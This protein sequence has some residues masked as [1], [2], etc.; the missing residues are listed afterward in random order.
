MGPKIATCCYCGTRAALKLKGDVQHE[1]ACGSCGAPLHEIKQMPLT[2][3]R[4]EKK[5][6]YETPVSFRKQMKSK[7]KYKKKKKGFLSEIFDDLDDIFEI[8][9]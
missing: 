5:Q 6:H 7:K 8:F 2:S 3:R 4:P 9:D 1:L